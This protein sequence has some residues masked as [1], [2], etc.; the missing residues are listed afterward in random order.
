MCTYFAFDNYY[1]YNFEVGAGPSSIVVDRVVNAEGTVLSATCRVEEPGTLTTPCATH[2]EVFV[3]T[4]ALSATCVY[5]FIPDGP[6]CCFGGYT[7]R[8]EYAV[9]VW[10]LEC[11]QVLQMGGSVGACLSDLRRRIQ[12][13]PRR[14]TDALSLS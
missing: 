9:T 12:N 7:F 8:G 3:D 5:N 10:E 4:L 2:P 6:N 14:W 13:G 1:Y 11:C